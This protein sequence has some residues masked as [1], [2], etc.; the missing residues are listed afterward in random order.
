MGSGSDTIDDVWKSVL[1]GSSCEGSV[2]VYCFEL[3]AWWSFWSFPLRGVFGAPR[4]RT[5]GHSPLGE[6]G[7][8]SL[9]RALL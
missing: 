4:T 5:A 6:A 3:E 2:L 9:S 1:G 7:H 8:G